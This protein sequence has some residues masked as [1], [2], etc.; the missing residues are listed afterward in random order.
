MSHLIDNSDTDSN[1]TIVPPF[2]RFH[3]DFSNDFENEFETQICN[4][5][6]VEV[7]AKHS[8][9]LRAIQ[10]ELRRQA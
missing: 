6:R 3:A 4:E 8:R 10:E 1:A 7:Q 9:E 2:N 5:I